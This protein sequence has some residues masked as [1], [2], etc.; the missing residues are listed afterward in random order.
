VDE[1][2]D[3]RGRGH[4]VAEDFAP[5]AEWHV[6]GDD[7]RG[8]FVAVADEAEDEVRGFG[9][10]GMCPTSGALVAR[11]TAERRYDAVAAPGVD[12]PLPTS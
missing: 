7:H 3:H 12:R 2:V 11:P 10:N 6:G 8:A 5:R 9:S 1:P 4:V